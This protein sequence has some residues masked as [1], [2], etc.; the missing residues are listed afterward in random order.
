MKYGLIHD[1][2]SAA[3]NQLLIHYATD[4]GVMKHNTQFHTFMTKGLKSLD[5]KCN[6]LI[7]T[8]HFFNGIP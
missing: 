4:N 8:T 5:M 1:Q 2:S 3:I 6:E 7:F